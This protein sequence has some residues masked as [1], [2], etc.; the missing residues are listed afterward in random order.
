MRDLAWIVVVLL[1]GL[2]WWQQERARDMA[3]SVERMEALIEGERAQR[4]I[5]DR[6]DSIDKGLQ[7]GGEDGLSDYMRGAAGKLWP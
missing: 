4:E 7:N 6:F 3:D 1:L 5:N 2:A